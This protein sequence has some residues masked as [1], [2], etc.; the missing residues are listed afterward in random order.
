MNCLK[1]GYDWP[2][3]KTCPY[4][5]AERATAEVTKLKQ[6]Y[7][8]ISVDDWL[9]TPHHDVLTV[10][11]YDSINGESSIHMVADSRMDGGEWEI[12]N[13]RVIHWRPLD[14]PEATASDSHCNHE[15]PGGECLKCG[16][17]GDDLLPTVADEQTPEGFLTVDGFMNA[18]EKVGIVPSDEDREWAR[19]WLKKRAD[20]RQ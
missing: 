8:W 3:D 11:E 14:W 20:D 5:D 16:K 6:Q 15:A 13:D 10:H 2:A 12:G 18:L 19:A 7:K 4:C 17:S 1:H 9:P